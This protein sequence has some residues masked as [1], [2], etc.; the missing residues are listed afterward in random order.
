[1]FP[2]FKIA[3]LSA[4]LSAAL[5][6]GFA[7]QGARSTLIP[8]ETA[9]KVFQDRVPQDATGGAAIVVAYASTA[10]RAGARSTR[11]GDML[12]LVPDAACA[13]QAWPYIAPE[14]LTAAE[15]TPVRQVARTVTVEQRGGPNTSVL[16]KGAALTL[17]AR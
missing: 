14:C 11:K 16:V 6:S 7:A 8:S 15:G 9:A 2:T 5:V 4:V 3:T 13:D 17:A 12:K 10:D 1:M